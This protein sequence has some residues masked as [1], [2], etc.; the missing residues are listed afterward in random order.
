[1]GSGWVPVA[2]DKERQVKTE[3]GGELPAMHSSSLSREEQT[4]ITDEAGFLALGSSPDFAP[5]P[6]SRTSGGLIC[7]GIQLQAT[8]IP[9]SDYSGGA[10]RGFVPPSPFPPPTRGAPPPTKKTKK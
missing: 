5:S 2:P 7:A 1:M 4:E 6:Y 8:E 10:A 9:L 3:D